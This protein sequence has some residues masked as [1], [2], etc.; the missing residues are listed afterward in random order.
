MARSLLM[1]DYP[2]TSH[3]LAS[4]FGPEWQAS[5]AKHIQATGSLRASAASLARAARK[6]QQ[7]KLRV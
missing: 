3:L 2:R 1:G 5:V 4:A 7:R 6:C